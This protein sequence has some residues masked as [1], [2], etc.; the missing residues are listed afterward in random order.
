M[1]IVL[2]FTSNNITTY[3][4][5]PFSY[6]LSNPDAGYTL[7]TTRTS[8]LPQ[9]YLTTT[10]SNVVFATSS[11]GMAVGTQS[12]TVT[13]SDASANPVLSSVNTVSILPGR[14]VDSNGAGFT[15][16]NYT[17]YAKEAFPPLLLRAPFAIGTPTSTP[18]L[19]PGL[20]LSVT[21]GSNVLLQG[22][23]STTVPQSNYLI[24]GKAVGS[25]KTVSSTLGIVVQGE[26]IITSVTPDAVVSGMTIGTPI[27]PR[28]FTTSGNGTFRYTWPT[29]LNGLGMT[30][31]LGVEQNSGFV[32]TDPSRTLILTGT[33]TL[34]AATAMKP[35]PDGITQTVR[36]E[37]IIP[38]PTL[39]SANVVSFAFGETVLFDPVTVPVLYSG[40]TLDPSATF[41]SASTYFTSNVPIASIAS[42]DLRSDLSLAFV[43]PRAYLTGT[44]LLPG[45]A[46]YTIRA[47]NSNG[48]TRDL[49][50]PI[51]VVTDTVTFTPPVDTSFTFVLSRP[52]DLPLTGYY[53]SPI[54]FSASATSGSSL[55]WSAPG[56]AST[57]LTLSST[58]G[59]L[60]GTPT[61]VTPPQLISI[62]AT[63]SLTSAT[64]SQ[65]I[66]I[67][68][69]NDQFTFASLG[70]FTF[71]QN[72]TIDPIQITATTLSGRPITSYSAVGLPS[73]LTC[74]ST[75]RITGAPTFDGSSTVTIS[76]STGF[77]SS[78]T[79]ISMTVLKDNILIVMSNTSETVPPV[80]S[81][82]EFRALSY[83]G[84]GGILTT[85]IDSQA[86][87]QGSNFTTSFVSGTTLQGNF[88]VVPVLLPEYRFGVTGTAGTY[89][90]TAEVHVLT[91]NAPI[92]ARNRVELTAL[93]NPQGFPNPI[94]P[95]G[96]IQLVRSTTTPISFTDALGFTVTSNALI[97]TTT[98][99]ASTIPYGLH[100]LAQNG[101]VLVATAGN[102]L[103]RSA[104]A[105]ATWSAVPSSNIQS[106]DV[107][108]GPAF[109]GTYYPP[110][111]GFGCIATD[112][113]SNWL[114]LAMG[115]GTN[116]TGPS[117]TI[118]R[119]SSDNGVTWRDTST[120][121]L[122]SLTITSNTKLVYASGRYFALAGE[123]N[124]TAPLLYADASNLSAWTAP[125]GFLG[126][127]LRDLTS[128][129]GTLVVVGD[130]MNTPTIASTCFVSSNSGTS[131]APLSPQPFTGT[132]SDM[133]VTSVKYAHGRWV[134]GA[135]VD[136]FATTSESTNLTSWS[137]TFG[138]P[139]T[140][141]ALVEDGGAWQLGGRA[142]WTTGLW[143]SNGTVAWSSTT[144]GPSPLY[145]SKRMT[146]TAV[147]TGS[148]TLTMSI[149]YDPSGIAFVSPTQTSYV[150][151]QFVPIAPITVQA[152]PSQFLYYYASDLPDG[153]TLVTDPSGLS[154]Q[155]TGTAVRFS[156]ARQT[157]LLYVALGSNVAAKILDMRTILPTVTSRQSSAGAWTS[158]LKQYTEVNGATT[159]RD[160]K[161]T[162][163]ID[164]RLGEFTSPEPPN[165]ITAPSNPNCQC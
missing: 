14:F 65:P 6:T 84:K 137:A 59:T 49:L 86:P 44:P 33:P 85:S 127:V 113:T 37:R 64:A 125:S 159:S 121:T 109:L 32:P 115:T 117:N 69:V 95:L 148:P 154:A 128:S 46:S 163:A 142:G 160:S 24:I 116:G 93:T 149:P 110:S 52:I 155:I 8:G 122:S 26:R 58:T 57:G 152:T 28:V 20:T 162:P 81:G 98:A 17:A 38:S 112:G 135:R 74:S 133:L 51:S 145:G 71:I 50:V 35:Y 144:S 147:S 68:V 18:S 101:S 114:A 164:Y 94:P 45:T 150:N 131:W 89:S 100:D 36:A 60:T 53:P 9:G 72:K 3:L 90:N 105:G 11:N 139:G 1:S 97:W 156:D 23:P 30:D 123:S 153:L 42:P 120:S 66:T 2:P 108:G 67:Q 31:S 19:P 10:S 130:D 29:L 27:T 83:S 22:T 136:G 40:V 54:T 70:P 82:V 41:F 106:I 80:F 79:T 132:Y 15:G 92:I 7:S 91:N 119:Q 47:T 76:A 141:T 62:T 118:L 25:S 138:Q 99:T 140:P 39:S 56:L 151:W 12:F 73:G 146:S 34:A 107:S 111:P 161:V 96:T 21:S 55:I 77:A 126:S 134:V 63:A 16:S 102:A 13:A 158:L 129:N 104:D 165:V 157:V 75:G 103:L 78:S 87:Y 88:S 61:T 43:A 143:T 4:Y 124:A 5:E 48:V